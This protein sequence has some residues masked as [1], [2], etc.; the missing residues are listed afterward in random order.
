MKKY[1]LILLCLCL[2]ISFVGCVSASP[3]NGEGETTDDSSGSESESESGSAKDDGMIIEGVHACAES[4]HSVEEYLRYL[5][6]VSLD[7]PAHNRDREEFH[8]DYPQYVSWLGK[9]K[10]TQKVVIPYSGE[11]PIDLRDTITLFEYDKWMLPSIWFHPENDGGAT[12]IKIAP[13][14]ENYDRTEVLAGL[15]ESETKTRVLKDGSVTAYVTKYSEDEPRMYETFFYQDLLIRIN[16]DTGTISDEFYAQLSFRE[17]E[18]PQDVPHL[19]I[20][21]EE[22]AEEVGTAVLF[23]GMSIH[24]FLYNFTNPTKF[25]EETEDGSL[26]IYQY[27]YDVK[28]IAPEESLFIWLYEDETGVR[29]VEKYEWANRREFDYPENWF[30][31]KCHAEEFWGIHTTENSENT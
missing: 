25:E 14:P 20:R 27:C 5:A 13:L 17:V 4:F 16:S 21:F 22:V 19:Y 2:C 15:A 23:E 31:C 24:L 6:V 18:L 29:F 9:V 1:L 28:D 8:M 10:D 30:P 26:I 12:I 11:N 7:I 3:P